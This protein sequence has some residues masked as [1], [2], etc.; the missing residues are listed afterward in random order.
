MPGSASASLKRSEFDSF[1]FA[2]VCDEKNGMAL[3]V[4]SA[5]ARLDVDPWLEAANLAGMPKEA[6][7]ER[8]TLSISRL[9]ERPAA[10]RDPEAIAYR[11][12][13]LLPRP[14]HS[15][16]PLSVSAPTYSR[17][18]IFMMLMALLLS[19][20]FLKGSRQSPAQEEGAH[21][22]ASSMVSPQISSGR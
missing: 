10:L 3:S 17:L 5:L 20:Q 4:L 14:G 2:S 1:L 11:L 13:A 8:L 9:S 6:A 16:A 12:I 22:S 18:A 15:A 7:I 19:S 21:A